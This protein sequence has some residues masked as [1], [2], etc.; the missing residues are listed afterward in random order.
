MKA[1]ANTAK[2]GGYGTERLVA[3]VA[4]A[5]HVAGRVALFLLAPVIGL[6]YVVAFP[7]VG[8]GALAWHGVRAVA[9]R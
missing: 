7:F 3:N 5:G 2:V 8:L 6:A 9:R 4:R 1:Y